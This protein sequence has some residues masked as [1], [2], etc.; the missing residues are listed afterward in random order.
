MVAGVGLCGR[1]ARATTGDGRRGAS[2]AWRQVFKHKVVPF[3]H[4][5]ER[6]AW[7][8]HHHWAQPAPVARVSRRMGVSKK[9]GGGSVA[10]ARE[11]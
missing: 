6:R 7:E 1:R 8:L 9:H 5:V 11:R 10:C 4:K 2:D 3:L